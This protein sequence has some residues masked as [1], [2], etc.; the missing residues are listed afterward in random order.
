M[1]V[2]LLV[3]LKA[4]LPGLVKTRLAAGIGPE[5]ALGAYRAMVADVLAAADASGLPTTLHFAPT[6]ALPAVRDLCGRDRTYRPQ[7]AGD[8]GARM[9]G[10]L[11]DAFAAGA[12]AALLVGG[13]LPLL[14]GSLLA[15]AAGLLATADAVLGPATDG[16]YYAIGFTR[17]GFCREAFADMPWSTPAVAGRTLAVLGRTGRRVALLP[18]LPDCDTPADLAALSRP[19][20]RELLAGTAFGAFLAA[21]PRDSFD[22]NP[23]Y[24]LSMP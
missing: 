16:G 10:A 13:D 12:G 17:A 2:R 3:C 11:A 21:L 23:A 4:P 14:T 18:A 5:A 20:W 15:R 22:H 6:D 8:L 19:P 1:D 9:A 24:R 7:A